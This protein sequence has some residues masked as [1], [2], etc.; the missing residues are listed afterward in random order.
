MSD[1]GYVHD[2]EAFDDDRPRSEYDEARAR[3]A[4]QEFDWRGWVLVGIIVV[5]FLVVPG[6]ILALPHAGGLL[7]AVGLT[8]RDTFLV[9]PL[10]PAVAL[11]I[12]AI[13]ATAR[14]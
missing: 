8:W 11:G 14:A 2:P 10:A 7:A 9:L 5:A 12:A 4:D 6:L 13:W 3:A 1:D